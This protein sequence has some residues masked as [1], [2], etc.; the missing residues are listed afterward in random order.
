MKVFRRAFRYMTKS[1]TNSVRGEVCARPLFIG[2]PLKGWPSGL[3]FALIEPRPI[4]KRSRELHQPVGR[5][6]TLVKT[7]ARHIPT[8]KFEFSDEAALVGFAHVAI[9]PTQVADG[10]ARGFGERVWVLCEVQI[11]QMERHPC[12]VFVVID[13]R[14][15]ALR[16]P[17]HKFVDQLVRYSG[18]ALGDIFG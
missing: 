4:L 7:P 11:A 10:T 16:G 12:E 1:M 18:A 15:P 2:R 14:L 6:F 9:T 17:N 8:E 3:P 13:F 5:P